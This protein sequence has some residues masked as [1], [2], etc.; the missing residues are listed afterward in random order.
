LAD[1]IS[2]APTL[3]RRFPDVPSNPSLDPQSGQQRLFENVATFYAALSEATPLLLV[4]EDVHWADSG[5]LS[6]LR[7]LARRTRHKRVLL[8]CTY[9]EA[10]LD[11]AHPFRQVLLDLHHERLAKRLKLPRLDRER[12]KELLAVLFNEEITADFLDGIYRETEGNPFFVEEVC[13]A[14]VERGDLYFTDGR[15]DRLSMEEL[16]IPQS[17]RMAIQSRVGKLPAPA[18]ETLRLAAVLGREF[19]FETLVEASAPSVARDP[20]EGSWQ[21]HPSSGSGQGRDEETLIHALERAERAQL[22]GELS[23]EGG[24]TFA[25]THALIPATLTEGLSGLRRRRMHRQVMAV[26]ERLRPEDLDALAFH[27]LQAGDLQQ[28]LDYSLRAGERAGRLCSP[29]DALRHYERAREVAESLALPEQLAI[30][31]EAIG[32]NQFLRD[33]AEAIDAFDHALKL[34]TEPE[35]RAGIKAKLGTTYAFVNDESGLPFLEAALEELNP[36]TQGNDLARAMMSFGRF[37]HN[38]GQHQQALSYLERARLLAEPLDDPYTLASIYMYLAGA[39]QQAADLSTSIEWARRNLDLGER[40]DYPFAAA[41]GYLYLA[42]AAIRMGAWQD[43][44]RYGERNRQVGVKSG[45]LTPIPWA[46]D[47]LAAA[48]YGLGDLPAAEASAQKSLHMAEEISDNRLVVVAGTRLSM[49]RTDLGLVELAES[50]AKTTVDRA[51]DL[52]CPQM[53]CD[54]LEAFAYWHLQCGEWESTRELLNQATNAIAGT[55]NRYQPLVGGPI[56]AAASLAAGRL[57]E[58]AKVV[59]RTLALAK[60]A[61]SP[62]IEAVTHRVQAQIFLAQGAW[63]DAA[64]CFDDAI[65][66]LDRL[67]SRLELGRALYHQGRMQADRGELE[68]ARFSLT[69]ALEILQDC[70]ARI[71]AERTRNALNAVGMG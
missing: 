35:K 13:K 12:T 71:D 44:L 2:L 34:T 5:S 67:G 31:H 33:V 61:P 58:A 19:D 53:L 56:H 3:R 45:I 55:D 57:E 14:L 23:A 22:I 24:G 9:R 63:D 1:L 62:H 30:I 69:R 17:V 37:H 36:D 59:E 29:E 68:D 8:V 40:K 7:H 47:N 6:L 50:N 42:Q 26:F 20:S 51:I 49:I 4:L 16:E 70:S 66:R 52:N 39:H 41:T 27:A 46:E 64:C 11:E 28:G 10:E 21:A 38:H 65:V 18:Q 43:A 60:E 32:D 15:W 54:S 25:F 48:Y